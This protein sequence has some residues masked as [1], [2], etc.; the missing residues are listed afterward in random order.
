MGG[1][2]CTDTGS[3]V[4][5]PGFRDAQCSCCSAFLSLF[6]CRVVQ[7]WLKV[8]PAMSGSSC[9]LLI[10]PVCLSC[11]LLVCAHC[12]VNVEGQQSSKALDGATFRQGG[13]GSLSHGV[14]RMSH[15]GSP[16]HLIGHKEQVD[17]PGFRH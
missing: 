10:Q 3:S 7:V 13:S 15:G 4:R 14:E 11:E 12:Q 1:V 17:F 9:A 5:C 16:A 2:D 8:G 6:P